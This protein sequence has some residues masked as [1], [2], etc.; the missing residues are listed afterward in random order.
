M[1]WYTTQQICSILSHFSHIH[2][3]GDSL[4]R[5]ISVAMHIL[6]REDLVEGGRAT[7]RKDNP[8]ATTDVEGNPVPAMDCRCRILFKKG[9]NCMWWEAINTD[10]VWADDPQSMKCGRDT[11]NFYVQQMPN[12]NFVSSGLDGWIDSIKARPGGTNK[13]NSVFILGA[14][15]WQFY[16]SSQT[17]DW[18]DAIEDGMR[19][20]IPSFFKSRR[21]WISPPAKG[22]N[23]DPR[24]WNRS[25]NIDIQHHIEDMDTYV[26][27]LGYD[28]LRVYNLTV[29]AS[30]PDG[31]H[32]SLE[33][34]LVEAM[35][36]LNWLD[37]VKNER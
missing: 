15:S 7:W 28:H 27:H 5:Q 24:Y 6:L 29:Q 10:Q 37:M 16:N 1:N 32:T 36:I 19:K 14:G 3:A 17:M 31:T 9:S 12:L 34:T 20:R 2:L 13:R 22:L 11:A 33:N 30:S 4:I 26:T 8:E 23:V 18:L 35:M 21:L 25:N